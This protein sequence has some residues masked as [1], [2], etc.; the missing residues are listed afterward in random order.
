MNDEHLKEIYEALESGKRLQYWVHYK[1]WVDD[2]HYQ[3]MATLP[4]EIVPT[5]WRVRVT[6]KI[7][8][9]KVVLGHDGDIG[10]IYR[11][12]GKSFVHTENST[13]TFRR[14]LTDGWVKI[15]Y[16]AEYDE[17]ELADW[18]FHTALDKMQQDGVQN[19][20]ELL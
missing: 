1:G 18:M 17:K 15:E 6:E 14:E 9:Y 3:S 2:I 4:P 19:F 12:D 20:Q 16:D 13:R 8:E 5:R 11:T 10:I 7:V